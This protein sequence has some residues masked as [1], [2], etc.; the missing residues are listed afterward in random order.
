MASHAQA[1]KNIKNFIKNP[2]KDPL[3]HQIRFK[4]KERVWDYL[5]SVSKTDLPVEATKTKVNQV[6][7]SPLTVLM[8]TDF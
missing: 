1:A 7:G 3:G 5:V 6:L 2:R 4:T 8:L